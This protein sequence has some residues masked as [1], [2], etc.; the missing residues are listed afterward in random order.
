ML[1]T[2]ENMLVPLRY[3]RS[4][5]RRMFNIDIADLPPKQGKEL[6][7][8]IRTEFRYKKTYDPATGT[9]RNLKSTQ[10]L[11]ED[12]WMSNR[13]GSRGT[14]VEM[15]DETGA[16]MNLEDIQHAAKKLYQSMKIPS[17]RNPYS[18][19][20]PT[21]SF[22]NTEIEQEELSFY[23][24][25]SRLKIPVIKMIKEIM[26]RQ[27]VA[28]GIFTDAEWREYE[29]NVQVVFS[30]ESMFLENM[31]KEIFLKNLESFVNLKDNIG[32]TISL[33]TAVK[34]TFGWSSEQLDEELN[35][36]KQE[37]DNPLYKSFYGRDESED[38]DPA[39]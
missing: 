12:Y 18:D 35:K 7:D 29:K 26:R 33:G 37:K 16:L 3:S 28:K 1:Q 24:Y 6:M 22:D 20:S 32:E 9:I 39:W 23:Q 19:E 30:N 5:S 13:S 36:I 27:L 21:F 38:A 25:I 31:K 34:N 17:S 14:T 4:V 15:L 10:P 8:K 11:V 2:L